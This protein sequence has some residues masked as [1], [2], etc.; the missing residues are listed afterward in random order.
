MLSLIKDR[1][2]TLLFLCYPEICV[3]FVKLLPLFWLLRDMLN[4]GV[5]KALFDVFSYIKIRLFQKDEGP[6]H[7]L[8]KVVFNEMAPLPNNVEAMEPLRRGR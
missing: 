2:R 8:R 7:S 3:K 4:V 6:D 5:K 1:K